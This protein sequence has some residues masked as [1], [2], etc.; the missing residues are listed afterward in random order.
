[1]FGLPNNIFIRSRCSTVRQLPGHMV[2]LRQGL[3][4]R[5]PFR[6]NSLGWG[7]WSRTS[8]FRLNRAA[9]YRLDHTPLFKL[10]SPNRTFRTDRPSI[11]S[12]F[13]YG[14]A[15]IRFE[16]AI[17]WTTHLFP[18]RPFARRKASRPDLCKLVGELAVTALRIFLP[19]NL[20]IKLW[21]YRLSL[22]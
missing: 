11:G 2:R 6:I 10:Y 7:G 9:P 18:S 20:K 16:M 5:C 14:Y 17:S 3:S 19:P 12:P 13:G 22:T 1:M 8:T 21:R 4:P 15:G